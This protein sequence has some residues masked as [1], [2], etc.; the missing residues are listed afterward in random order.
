MLPLTPW[1]FRKTSYSV[2]LSRIYKRSKLD[3][4]LGSRVDHHL[5]HCVAERK[6]FF[7][8]ILQAF[9]RLF[10]WYL[11]CPSIIKCW[12]KLELVD[13]LN[14]NEKLWMKIT[15]LIRDQNMLVDGKSVW[16]SYGQKLFFLIS[17]SQ[18]GGKNWLNNSLL[19]LIIFKQAPR[20]S[21]CDAGAVFHPNNSITRK[22]C[23]A[24]DHYSS[25]PQFP[26]LTPIYLLERC[27]IKKLRIIPAEGSTYQVCDAGASILSSI[28]RVSPGRTTRVDTKG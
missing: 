21:F 15:E 24:S 3:F 23:R 6:P 27:V 17:Q 10:W 28:F 8:N 18:H 11:F 19:M 26:W 14:R 2:S 9:Y 12:G 22:A 5:S 20:P 7:P 25:H 16:W 1:G 13:P 4:Y